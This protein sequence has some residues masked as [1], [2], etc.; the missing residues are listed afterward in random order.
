MNQ[1][2][3]NDLTVELEFEFTFYLSLI[4]SLTA[5]FPLIEINQFFYLCVVLIFEINN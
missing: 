2:Y 1:K 4:S 3:N 5:R